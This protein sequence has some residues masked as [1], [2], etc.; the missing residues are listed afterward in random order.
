MS[1]S[2]GHDIFSEKRSSLWGSLASRS[3]RSKTT[4]P[5]ARPERGLDGVG[6][7]PLAAR[8]DDQPVDDDLDGVLA[9]LLQR[10]GVGELHGLAVDAGPAVALGLQRAEE[11]E[12]LAL[13]TA[14][15]RRQHLEAGAL[16]ELHH[17]V[18]DLLRGLALDGGV[19]DRQ[20]GRPARAKSSRR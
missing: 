3:T 12:V 4:R 2:L 5:E 17:A 6:E 9:L 7:P 13:A 8:L 18:D 1:C 10:R 15:D 19:A 16:L 11:L 20:C 14:D